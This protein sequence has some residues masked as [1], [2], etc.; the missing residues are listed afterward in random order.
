MMHLF[1]LVALYYGAA[2]RKW[3]ATKEAADVNKTFTRF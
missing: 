1:C 2:V 3:D